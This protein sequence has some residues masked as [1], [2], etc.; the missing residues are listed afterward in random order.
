[1]KYISKM[2][3][4]LFVYSTSWSQNTSKTFIGGYV[5]GLEIEKSTVKTPLIG[6]SLQWLGTNEATVTDADAYFKIQKKPDHNYLII[7]ML[8]YKTDTVKIAPTSAELTLNLI[9][10]SAVLS[11]VEVTTGNFKI[12][13]L[14]PIS[15]EIIGLKDLKKAACCNLSESFETN[16]SV[17]VSYADAITGAK[18]IQLLGLNGQYIQILI[19]LLG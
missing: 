6:A 9:E 15:N 17:S 14:N 18:Q 2:C 3:F 10:D 8:G 16:A 13:K 1:M 5:Y 19:P 4:V 7:K 12:D 11:A